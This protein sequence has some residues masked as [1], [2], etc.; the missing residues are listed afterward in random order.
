MT[1]VNRLSAELL[2]TLVPGDQVVIESAADVGRPRRFAGTVV[3]LE[4]THI[5]V[6]CCSP[7]GIR[8]VQRYGRRDG[9][10][11]GGGHQAVLVNADVSESATLDQRRQ[12]LR[13][14]AL[15]REW[16]RNRSDLVRL[17]RLRAAIGERLHEEATAGTA[18]S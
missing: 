4:G 9:I 3:R 18:S 14:E 1:V 15:Y 5:V 17:R 11:D 8:Y 10:R 2:A 6:T 7:R 12:A 13:L 16:T